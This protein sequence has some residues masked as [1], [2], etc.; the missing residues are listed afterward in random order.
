MKGSYSSKLTINICNRNIKKNDNKNPKQIF[1]NKL[2]N[3][4]K[5]KLIN[6]NDKLNANAH[7]NTKNSPSVGKLNKT[8]NNHND[9]KTVRKYSKYSKQHDNHRM[10]IPKSK[11]EEEVIFFKNRF[12]LLQVDDVEQHYEN[13]YDTDS[14]L[15]E[16]KLM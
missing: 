10:E 11:I 2:T 5:E 15:G 8:N 3:N 12:S 9:F 7:I 4:V 16:L 13:T 14:N 6:D 1:T